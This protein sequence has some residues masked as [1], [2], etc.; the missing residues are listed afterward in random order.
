MS[1]H[2]RVTSGTLL[3]VLDCDRRLWLSEHGRTRGG[4]RSEHDDMLGG[5]S[6]S[7]EDRIAQS[8]PDLAGPMLAHGTR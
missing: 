4:V 1:A 5:R 7:L 6:R 2:S 8:L 3:R